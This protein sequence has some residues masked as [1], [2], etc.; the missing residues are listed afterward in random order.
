MTSELLTPEELEEIQSALER[1]GNSFSELMGYQLLGHIDALTKNLNSTSIAEIDYAT[2]SSIDNEYVY[3]VR[4]TQKLQI[5]T[6]LY[7]RLV[8]S[9]MPHDF[10]S[11]ENTWRQALE[12]LIEL[13]PES[14]QPDMDERGFWKHELY[15]FNRAYKELLAAAQSEAPAVPDCILRTLPREG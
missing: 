5:G 10:F 1:G 14:H 3:S 13:E 8:A 9:T 15:A 12:R 4:S 2:A 11:H 6:K 7:A